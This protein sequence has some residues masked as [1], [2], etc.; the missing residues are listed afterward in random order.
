MAGSMVRREITSGRLIIDA[1]ADRR[2]GVII[3]QWRQRFGD[4]AVPPA[5]PETPKRVIGEC[6]LARSIGWAGNP[7]QPTGLLRP[8]VVALTDRCA[9]ARSVPWPLAQL[10]L[11]R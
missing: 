11:P 6:S 4:Q 9:Q 5:M 10:L 8:G 2:N 7:G 1:S 3:E